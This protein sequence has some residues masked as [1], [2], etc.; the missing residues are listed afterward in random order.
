MCM[1]YSSIIHRKENT[2]ERLIFCGDSKVQYRWILNWMQMKMENI[3]KWHIWLLL[4]TKS[5]ISLAMKKKIRLLLLLTVIS[6]ISGDCWRTCRAQLHLLPDFDASSTQEQISSLVQHFRANQ[7]SLWTGAPSKAR[8][9]MSEGGLHCK[10][11]D[12][13]KA[14]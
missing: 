13:Q 1:F 7:S 9:G 5:R 11:L 12:L 3:K 14:T 6:A 8:N 4:A 2:K 10:L